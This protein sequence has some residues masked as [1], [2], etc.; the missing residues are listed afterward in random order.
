[1]KDH[2]NA[3]RRMI[4][5]CHLPQGRFSLEVTIGIT[6]KIHSALVPFLTYTKSSEAE[7]AF[8]NYYDVK[9]VGIRQKNLSVDRVPS[10][11]DFFTID[12]TTGFP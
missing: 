12:F 5:T 9:Q 6:L 3:S 11:M 8:S 7:T 1:M 2:I 4:T 10:K